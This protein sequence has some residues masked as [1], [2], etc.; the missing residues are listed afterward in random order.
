MAGIA[1]VGFA[2][3]LYGSPAQKGVSWI[4]SLLTYASQG[5]SKWHRISNS[6]FQHC[7]Q[8]AGLVGFFPPTT[9]P[10]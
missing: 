2:L 10:R 7:E 9:I 3:M 5:L 1:S 6:S 8:Q 4:H